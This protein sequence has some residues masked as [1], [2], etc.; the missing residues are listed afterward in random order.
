MGR[1]HDPG[2]PEDAVVM[3][4]TY[5][6]R[7]TLYIDGE[8]LGPGGRSTHTV[9]NPATGEPLGALP[10]A[11]AADLDRALDAAARGFRLWRNKSADDRAAIL[12]GAARLLRERMEKIAAT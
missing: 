2:T 3:K 5:D 10:L 1:L 9:V 6:T 12:A 11:T 7:L 4:Q 8:R